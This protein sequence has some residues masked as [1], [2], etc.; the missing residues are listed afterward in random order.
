MAFVDFILL[1]PVVLAIHNF[2]EYRGYD[3]FVRAYPAWLAQK[4]TRRVVGRAA[5]LLT[6]AITVLVVL[7]YIYRSDLLL[8]L[9]KIAIVAL[10]L[11]CVGHCLF[12]IKRHAF[13]PGTLSGLTLAL[14]YSVIAV[15]MMGTSLGDSSWLLFAYATIGAVL[16]PIAI[17]AFLWISYALSRLTGTNSK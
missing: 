12:S 3:D 15:V 9:S 7:T 8:T 10:G 16:T 6:L 13:V 1:F 17:G 5:I 2:D 14:P 4:L 11:N